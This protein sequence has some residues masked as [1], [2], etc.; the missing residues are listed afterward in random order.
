MRRVY[1]IVQRSS[2][3]AIWLTNYEANTLIFE[4]LF[5]ILVNEYEDFK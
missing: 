4:M 1:I 5:L 2:R 3:R